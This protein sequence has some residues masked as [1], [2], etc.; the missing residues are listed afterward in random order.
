MEDTLWGAVRTIEERI[1]L[2]EQVERHVRETAPGGGGAEEFERRAQE[3]ARI[4]EMVREAAMRNRA[5]GAG[6]VHS[7]VHGA[8]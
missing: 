8:D 2:L 4:A 6:S 7:S 1:L 5:L 3:A